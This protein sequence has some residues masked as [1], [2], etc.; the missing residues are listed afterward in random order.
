MVNDVPHQRLVLEGDGFRGGNKGY[1]EFRV[2][3]H[4]GYRIHDQ[5]SPYL[6]V[7]M[8]IGPLHWG[9]LGGEVIASAVPSRSP[10]P[11]DIWRVVSK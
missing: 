7:R 2:P 3:L 9:Q 6:P 1:S 11:A 5:K 8:R 10:A 4:S